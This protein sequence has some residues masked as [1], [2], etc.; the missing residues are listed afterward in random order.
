MEDSDE[1]IWISKED[2]LNAI[3][4]KNQ[5]D[6]LHMIAKSAADGAYVAAKNGYFWN[7]DQFKELMKE[8]MKELFLS[9]PETSEEFKKMMQK[10]VKTIFENWVLDSFQTTDMKKYFDLVHKKL[11]SEAMK[12]NIEETSVIEHENRNFVDINKLKEF[13]DKNGT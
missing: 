2:I 10:S 1:K 8:T 5:S 12:Y 6:L 9:S 4:G 13:L 3:T 11:K 7:L